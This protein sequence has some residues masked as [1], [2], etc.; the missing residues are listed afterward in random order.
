MPPT[1]RSTTITIDGNAQGAKRA[2]REAVDAVRD[3]GTAVNQAKADLDAGRISAEQFAQ[4]VKAIGGANVSE[5]VGDAFIELNRAL[6]EARGLYDANAIS[7][8]QYRERLEGIAQ[9]AATVRDSMAR[10]GAEVQAFDTVIGEVGAAL[11]ATKG[12]VSAASLAFTDLANQLDRVKLGLKEGTLSQSQYEADL[13]G[14][15][16]AVQEVGQSHSLSAA[17]QRTF[18]RLLSQTT[19]TVRPATEAMAAL[20]NQLAVL[21]GQL[22]AGVISTGQFNAE[23]RTLNADLKQIA[24][25]TELSGAEQRTF[26]GLLVA[27]SAEAAP[28]AVQGL[29]T[30]RSAMASMAV[31]MLGARSSLGSLISGFGLMAAGSTMAL[32]VVAAFTGFAVVFDLVTGKERKVAEEADHL[33]DALNRQAHEGVPA[34]IRAYNDYITTLTTVAQKEGQLSLLKGLEGG[35]RASG[36]GPAADLVHLFVTEGQLER[37]AAARSALAQSKESKDAASLQTLLGDASALATLKDAGQLTAE[38]A[39]RRDDTL[40][41]L[42]V[43][44][45]MNHTLQERAQIQ[46]AINALTRE[47][48]EH[49]AKARELTDLEKLDQEMIRREQ[50]QQVKVSGDALRAAGGRGNPGLFSIPAGVGPSSDPFAPFFTPEQAAAL[51]TTLEAGMDATLP[52]IAQLKTDVIDLG[53][54]FGDDAKQGAEDL[55]AA[56]LQG[57][58]N[59]GNVLRSLLA[60][61]AQ[62]ASHALFNSLFGSVIGA[63]GRAGTSGT[64]PN[65]LPTTGFV[66]ATG[67][68]VPGRGTGD[69]VPAM[70]TPGEYVLTPSAVRSIGVDQLHAWNAGR[71]PAMGG[72]LGGTMEH[73]FGGGM[74]VGLEPGLVARH[75]DAYLDTPRGRQRIASAAASRPRTLR[76]GLNG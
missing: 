32:G 47:E 42:V 56:I 13:V 74:T 63:A 10:S 8:T 61:L 71:A 6:A 55:F 75:L 57:G 26:N 36:N 16:A 68:L 44:G 76:D 39:A 1:N 15:K 45:K 28:K 46:S 64:G 70:L 33:V 54:A 21:R 43:A 4:Q 29:G 40:I 24:A 72:A 50:A 23:L 17:E 66:F 11:D 9:T 51:N 18:Q 60:Q 27:T 53:A 38:D 14:L 52:K 19:V 5:R 35:L 73:T 62:L 37:V 58:Q 30:M 7:A 48:T 22:S 12:G 2:A 20:Q 69:T 65:L 49:R 34:V 3:V 31:Q 67:G 41:G 25:T 59:A